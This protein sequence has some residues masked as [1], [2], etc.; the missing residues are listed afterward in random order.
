MQKLHDDLD[1]DLDTV[2]GACAARSRQT[3]NLKSLQ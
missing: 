2:R 1:L 3:I